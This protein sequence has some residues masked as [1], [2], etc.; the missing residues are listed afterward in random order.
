[1]YYNVETL[2]LFVLYCQ[3]NNYSRVF[4]SAKPGCTMTLQSS[5]TQP[6]IAVNFSI[7]RWRILLDRFSV[8]ASRF[9]VSGQ[10]TG[11]L[12]SFQ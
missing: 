11:E 12:G 3:P 10:I 9:P 7:S 5:Q 4:K 2:R 1:M 6:K 8:L